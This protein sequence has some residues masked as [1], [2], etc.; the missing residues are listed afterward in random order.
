MDCAEVYVEQS[1]TSI[2]NC[3]VSF[4]LPGF[5]SRTLKL[6]EMKTNPFVDLDLSG[7]LLDEESLKRIEEIRWIHR[8][9]KFLDNI[10]IGN[11][12]KSN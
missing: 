4:E 12:E 9:L 3:L 7:W 10:K 6:F 11:D 2:F 1:L 5:T 8:R